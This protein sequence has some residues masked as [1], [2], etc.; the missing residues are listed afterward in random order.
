MF[1]HVKKERSN[2]SCSSLYTGSVFFI[3]QGAI[4]KRGPVQ[5]SF[6]Y[7]QYDEAK[8]LPV[9][10]SFEGVNAGYDCFFQ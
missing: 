3:T 1:L 4:T 2:V 7:L 6:K 9:C 8:K 5:Y 10:G